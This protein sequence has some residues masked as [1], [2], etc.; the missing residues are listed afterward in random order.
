MVKPKQ[1][2]LVIRLSAMGD[3]AMTVPVLRALI[4][5]YP[6]IKI[7]V[8][9]R[10]FFAPFF[11]DLSNVT[12]FPAEVKKRHKG[13]LGLWKLSNEL[14]VFKI[15]A[16]ADLH[17]VLRSQILKLFFFGKQT[18]QIDKGRAEKKALVSGE[19]F[20]QLKTT[21]QRYADVFNKLG[22]NLD[23]SNPTFPERAV[24]STEMQVFLGH[25]FKKIIG[26]APFAA[27]AGKMYPLNLM[28]QVI[29]ALSKDY[30]IVLFGGGKQEIEALTAIENSFDNVVNSA[31]KL[32]LN[33]ELDLISNLDGMLAMDSGNAHMAAMMGVKTI[34]IWGVTH[35][36]AGFA[37]F[38]QPNDYALVANKDEFPEIP[39]SI[40][41]NKYPEN[42]KEAA[43][44]ITPETV[45]RKV[46]EV[47]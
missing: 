34:T 15:D 24:L 39:T 37:P 47:F 41:G 27:H 11:R 7:T 19:N 31:G 17:N 43:G 40:F 13:V 9:T 21:H 6:D 36:F 25:N 45:V 28:K 2:I 12:V 30:Q 42:Y 14:K 35:P 46:T 29:E 38:N 33:E 32:N 10:E 8:L 44:S 20:Q 3:V 4:K 16:I 5:N 18:I 26:I 23:L 22:Y 1:H